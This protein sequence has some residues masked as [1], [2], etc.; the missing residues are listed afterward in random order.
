AQEAV[1]QETPRGVERV[2]PVGGIVWESA[3]FRGVP[4]V[5]I[6]GAVQ[7]NWGAA[8]N[9][10]LAAGATLMTIREKRLKACR[11]RTVTTFGGYSLGG[12]EDCLIDSDQDGRF[13]KVSFNEV[14]GSKPINPP[15]GYTKILVPVVGE[16]SAS[17]RKTITFLGKSGPDIRLSYREFSND[18]AR[19][20]FTEDLSFPVPESFPT[21]MVV[22]DLKLT[23]LGLDGNG[24]RYRIDGV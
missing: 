24:L 16:G 12:W 10:N 20:A 21:A 15:V 13:E 6:E 7:A 22:K 17:F 18:M 19:P 11:A 2:A 23:L 8:E 5:Q 3:A 4:G 1:T 9:V 14:G